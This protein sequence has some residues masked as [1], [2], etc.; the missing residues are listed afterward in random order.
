MVEYHSTTIERATKKD[1]LQQLVK[2]SGDAYL[3]KVTTPLMRRYG[4][5]YLSKALESLADDGIILPGGEYHR[6]R[7]RFAKGKFASQD[8]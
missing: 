3:S 7:V 1:L 6:I 4:V 8:K 2:E 5:Y